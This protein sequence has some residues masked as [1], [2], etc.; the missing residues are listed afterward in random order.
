MTDLQLQKVTVKQLMVWGQ[1]DNDRILLLDVSCMYMSRT[2]DR[3]E[4][5]WKKEEHT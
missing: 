3:E 1:W 5:E 4:C 2:E